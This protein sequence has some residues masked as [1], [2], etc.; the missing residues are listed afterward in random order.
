M[1]PVKDITGV[2]LAGGKSSRFGSNKALAPWQGKPLIQH[3][4]DTLTTVFSDCLIVTNA[5]TEY[6]FLGLPMISDMFQDMGPLAGI[7]AALRHADN[8][9]IFVLACD[10][11]LVTSSL[12]SFICGFA[13]PKY[14]AV[15]PELETGPEPL[16][17]LYH[18][19]T[20]PAIEQQL[21]NGNL[22]VGNMLEQFSVRRVS[23][24]ELQSISVSQQA[25]ANVNSG[26]DLDRLT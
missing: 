9:W 24:K 18:K 15:V 19:N 6:E 22:G 7:H 11:P 5:P 23:E 21:Q 10:M 8:Q 16:C 4:A 1:K 2:I 14:D 13:D 20:M 26:Q 3:A 12:I 17:C 25:F